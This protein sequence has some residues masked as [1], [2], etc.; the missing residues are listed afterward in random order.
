[1]VNQACR[2]ISLSL[3]ARHKGL[4]AVVTA[5]SYDHGAHGTRFRSQP[6]GPGRMTE[7]AGS[8]GHILQ[9]VSPGRHARPPPSIARS[10][11]PPQKLL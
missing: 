11:Q 6:K 10:L 3:C 9:S 7:V 2:T 5:G 8:A 1:V 4:L